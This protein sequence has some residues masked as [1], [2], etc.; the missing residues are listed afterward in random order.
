MQVFR[1]LKL[2][3]RNMS[4]VLGDGYQL[5][6]MLSRKQVEISGLLCGDG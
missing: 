1:L 6:V 5:V 2:K 3:L 4:L